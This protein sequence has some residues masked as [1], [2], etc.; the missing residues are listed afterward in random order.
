MITKIKLALVFATLLSASARP[1]TEYWYLLR[2][3]DAYV[4]C[5]TVLTVERLAPNAIY[6][7]CH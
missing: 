1:S 5:P 3:N 6:L 4:I 7:R 2:H